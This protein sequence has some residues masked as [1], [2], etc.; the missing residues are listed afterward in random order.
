[1][2]QMVMGTRQA[3]SSQ[4][5]QNQELTPNYLHLCITKKGARMRGTAQRK[6]RTIKTNR[7][8][9]RNITC[10]SVMKHALFI[11]DQRK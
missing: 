4:D 6:T 3:K 8:R 1:M 7:K 9:E 11:K 5:T 2:K 10:R